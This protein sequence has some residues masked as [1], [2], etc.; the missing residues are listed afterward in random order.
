MSDKAWPE[1]LQPIQSGGVA[2]AIVRQLG[3]LLGSG[4]LEPGE[5]LPT[6]AE[7]AEIFG[8]SPMTVRN[9]LQAMRDYGL[10]ETRRGRGAGTFVRQDAAAKLQHE[11]G[12]FPTLEAYSDFTVWR[13]AVSGEAC[14]RAARLL[15]AGDIA[16]LV[17]LAA[18][19]DGEGLGPDEYRLADAR[20]H[21]H[22]AELAQSPRLVEAE[23]Q[24]QTYL[25]RTLSD[26]GRAPDSKQFHAQGHRQL[27]DAIVAGDEAGAR[28]RFAD[29]ARATVDVLAGLGYLRWESGELARPSELPGSGQP[30]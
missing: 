26:T 18:S 29:H 7:L 30:A 24:I 3:E 8:V 11:N 19:A 1:V 10:V 20:L 16:E 27:I 14:A 4:Q 17:R 15:E 9:A 22:I 2:E 21:M 5:R 12:D 6:E 13:E 23:Q 25:T 28:A